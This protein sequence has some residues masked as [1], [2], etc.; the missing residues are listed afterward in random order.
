MDANFESLLKSTRCIYIC[1]VTLTHGYSQCREGKFLARLATLSLKLCIRL[2]KIARH[3]SNAFNQK[4]N[5]RKSSVSIE[6]C[7]VI[8]NKEEK[9]KLYEIF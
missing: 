2:G 9:I 5:W 1:I 8:W 7:V 4:Q 6:H 3:C